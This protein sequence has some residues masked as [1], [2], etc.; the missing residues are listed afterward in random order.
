MPAK[1]SL[2][3]LPATPTASV[4]GSSSGVTVVADS[5]ARLSVAEGAKKDSPRLEAAAASTRRRGS[6]G[7]FDLVNGLFD[8][9]RKSSVVAGPSH[10]AQT[11]ADI[12][13]DIVDFE[14]LVEGLK[15]ELQEVLEHEQK[16]VEKDGKANVQ[17]DKTIEHQKL[18]NFFAEKIKAIKE[19]KTFGELQQLFTI[20]EALLKTDSNPVKQFNDI[21]RAFIARYPQVDPETPLVNDIMEVRRYWVSEHLNQAPYNVAPLTQ[22]VLSYLFFETEE[23]IKAVTAAIKQ[24]EQHDIYPQIKSLVDK[25][26]KEYLNKGGYKNFKK[27]SLVKYVQ[28]AQITSEKIVR[29]QQV[30][31][32]YAKKIRAEYTGTTHIQFA[33]YKR[34]VGLINTT[35][36]TEVNAEFDW[37][38]FI[39]NAVLHLLELYKNVGPN[40]FFE[41]M[42]FIMLNILKSPELQSRMKIF[43]EYN[44]WFEKKAKW[45]AEYIRAMELRRESDTKKINKEKP[46]NFNFR[47]ENEIVFERAR[48]FKNILINRIDLFL[49][50]ADLGRSSFKDAA[51]DLIIYLAF[52]LAQPGNL[53]NNQTVCYIEEEVNSFS[54][55]DL[56][57]F[58]L[59]IESFLNNN[60]LAAAQQLEYRFAICQKFFDEVDIFQNASLYGNAPAVNPCSEKFGRLVDDLEKAMQVKH[61]EMLQ[62]NKS[63]LP[64][65]WKKFDTK[66]LPTKIAKLRESEKNKQ[67]P[68]T[69]PAGVRR[70]SMPTNFGLTPTATAAAATAGLMQAAMMLKTSGATVTTPVAGSATAKVFTFASPVVGNSAAAVLDKPPLNKQESIPPP[71]RALDDDGDKTSDSV[72]PPPRPGTP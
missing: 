6:S 71:P 50:D 61:W 60:N 24:R 46:R 63:K 70:N 10:F 49:L 72:L 67:S 40:K 55:V 12:K 66:D 44:A 57:L 27:D 8:S 2:P 5:K 33:R 15:H 29:F 13:V 36:L 45:N 19:V 23:R 47:G 56:D 32:V 25:D 69:T 11:E 41:G 54:E 20:P 21:G 43:E 4:A 53:I 52:M 58:K 51:K 42:V 1:S 65:L 37:L 7:V 3:K 31:K 68:A 9:V 38:F 35:K 34:F 64:A 28:A 17:N 18:R 16:K 48:R 14:L 62:Q 26:T 59:A 30:V 22:L 39:R